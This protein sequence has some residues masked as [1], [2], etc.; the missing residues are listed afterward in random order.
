MVE[1]LQVFNAVKLHFLK[2]LKVDCS[3]TACSLFMQLIFD[4]KSQYGW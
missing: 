3:D 1:L 4:E 2:S